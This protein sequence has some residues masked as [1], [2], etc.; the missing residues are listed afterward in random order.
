MCFSKVT[1]L[2][3]LSSLYGSAKLNRWSIFLKL[4]PPRCVYISLSFISLL[5][6]AATN[7]AVP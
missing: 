4:L 7:R 1:I 5:S 2:L 3:I 6:P